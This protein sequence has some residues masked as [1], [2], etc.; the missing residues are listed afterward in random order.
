MAVSL[1]SVCGGNS[2]S[3]FR[4]VDR[5][6]GVLDACSFRA[7]LFYV[8]SFADDLGRKWFVVVGN[9]LAIIG[10]IICAT[11]H[12]VQVVIVGMAIAGLGSCGQQMSLAAISEVFPRKWRGFALGKQAFLTNSN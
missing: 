11:A 1:I 12:S 4:F 3:F 7:Y 10:A 8:G 2:V 6:L 5:P 9:L